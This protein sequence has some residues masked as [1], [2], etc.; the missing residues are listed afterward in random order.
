MVGSTTFN[1]LLNEEVIGSLP[2][3]Y[4]KNLSIFPNIYSHARSLFH[5]TQS[6]THL[7]SMSKK[8]N[9]PSLSSLLNKKNCPSPVDDPADPSSVNKNS[10]HLSSLSISNL[11]NSSRIR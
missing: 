5:Q 8:K 11:L 7:S 9:R 2:V 1:F 10:K 4:R 6:L 3:Q